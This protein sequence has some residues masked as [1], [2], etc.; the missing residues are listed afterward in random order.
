MNNPELILNK[1]KEQNKLRSKK[2]YDKN[3]ALIAERR[4]AQR[5]SNTKVIKEIV[6][7][8]MIN[9]DEKQQIKQLQHDV[10]TLNSQ[11]IT[12]KT[13]NVNKIRLDTL[14]DKKEYKYNL[15]EAIDMINL[16]VENENSRKNYVNSIKT[17]Y[18]ILRKDGKNINNINIKTKL[19][20]FKQVVYR[21]NTVLQAK[22]NEH[23]SINSKKSFIQTILKLITLYDGLE[24]SKAAIDHY[25]N[26]FEKLKL[27]SNFETEK[28]LEEEVMN[29]N[30]YL[31]LIKK[32]YGEDSK[33]YLIINF[34]KISGFRDDI[35]FFIVSSPPKII[36][37][38]INYLVVPTTKS[39]N[40]HIILNQYKTVKKYG[41]KL[42][43]INKDD[44]KLI[45]N[46]INNNDIENNS[47][48]FNSKSQSSFIIKMNKKIG[49]NISINKL[50]HM[51][52]ST[53]LND[54]EKVQDVE[55]RLKLAGKM[56]HSTATS[57]KTYK[58][59]LMVF[60]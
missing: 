52:V 55:E 14:Q 35:S 59:K 37:E 58:N 19:K 60:V 33:E 31:K 24:L 56:N 16:N 10:K 54:N 32:E 39:K 29:F 28:K 38:D 12:I 34:Y 15:D 41:P 42:I 21:L 44:S 27:S 9:K 45:R 53:T 7:V 20:Q 13:N 46:Y 49:L 5:E 25:K 30:D 8:P 2:Y 22:K 3:K 43:N 17:I 51:I 47:Y 50:R 23:Y 40:L 36:N 48:L 1:I 26:E 4:K 57:T 6:E 11:L 18:D